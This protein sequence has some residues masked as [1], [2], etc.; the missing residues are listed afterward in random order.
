MRKEERIFDIIVGT[1]VLISGFASLHQLFLFEC[2]LVRLATF[3]LNLCVGIL[4]ISR[5]SVV[6]SGTIRSILIS[7]PSFAL[8][9][10]LFKISHP[11]SNWTQVN[12]LFFTFFTLLTCL[13]L[14]YL[15]KNFSVFPNLRS[16]SKNGPYSL[17]RHPIYASEL[18]LTSCCCA[19]KC[20]ILTISLLFLFIVFLIFRI[21]E[22]EKLLVLDENYLHYKMSVKWRLFP[23]IW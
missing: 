12:N 10:V 22:E 5:R 3:V 14:L 20:S 19:A 13:S 7:F 9:G 17:I 6:K 4:F 16:I 8:G 2:S 11:L 15:G 18:G 21:K 23:H 1:S